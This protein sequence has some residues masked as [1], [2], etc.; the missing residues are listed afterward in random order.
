MRRVRLFSANLF[1]PTIQVYDKTCVR[2]VKGTHGHMSTP[3]RRHTVE[4]RVYVG[5]AKFPGEGGRCTKCDLGRVFR[6]GRGRGKTY[7]RC[8]LGFSGLFPTSIN[9]N[10]YLLFHRNMH[11]RAFFF[12]K[13]VADW[14][15]NETGCPS[16][17]GSVVSEPWGGVRPCR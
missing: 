6:L 14:F 8:P 17:V 16:S 1:L 3:T 7:I 11:R 9:Q 5:K 15:P 12:F 4:I 13:C 2:A 10:C